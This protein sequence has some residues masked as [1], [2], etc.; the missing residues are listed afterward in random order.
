MPGAV[1]HIKE[2]SGETAAVSYKQRVIC[3]NIC[4]ITVTFESRICAESKYVYRR[5][6]RK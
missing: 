4:N 6:R 1:F 5:F 3:A 2:K